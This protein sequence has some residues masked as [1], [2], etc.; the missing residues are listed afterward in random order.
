MTSV[1]SRLIIERA[2]APSGNGQEAIHELQQNETVREDRQ[3][4]APPRTSQ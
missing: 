4:L 3:V 1:T 2:G